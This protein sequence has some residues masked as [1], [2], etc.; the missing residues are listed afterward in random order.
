M[1]EFNSLERNT[2]FNQDV[3]NATLFF[4]TA[5]IFFWPKQISLY[6][7]TVLPN[8]NA[9]QIE[10]KKFSTSIGI[11]GRLRHFPFRTLSQAG[12]PISYTI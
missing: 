2:D 4:M 6:L 5:A 3:A 8:F 12:I 7:L 1:F 10:K 11:M 9:I